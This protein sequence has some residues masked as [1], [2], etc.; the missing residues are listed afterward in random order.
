MALKRMQEILKAPSPYRLIKETEGL[1]ATVSTVNT[2]FVTA[3]RQQAMTK[4]DGHLATVT[5]DIEAAKGDAGLHAA[6]VKLLEALKSAVQI[7][8]SLAHITQAETEA[9]KEF[10]VATSRIEEFVRKATEQ[11]KDKGTGT[12]HPIP[13]LKKK[14]VIEPAKLV[15]DPYLETQADVER[16]LKMLRKELEQAL[17]KNERIEIR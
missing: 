13:I 12:E 9:L 8:D 14:R 15:L 17:A 3:A 4:I 5:K 2:A 6:C 16:F 11:P 10:D 1:I 7:E